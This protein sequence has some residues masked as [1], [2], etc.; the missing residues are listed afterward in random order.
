GA[1]GDRAS[2]RGARPPRPAAVR[3]P[4]VAPRPPQR[5]APARQ[6]RATL[7]RGTAPG[8][9]VAGLDEPDAAGDQPLATSA[10][11]GAG[12]RRDAA[13]TTAPDTAPAADSAADRGL[14][15]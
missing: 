6:L 1:V 14:P 8:R 7:A 10:A 2:P 9:S 15:H 12:V 13:G 11:L 4:E 5:A 3:R